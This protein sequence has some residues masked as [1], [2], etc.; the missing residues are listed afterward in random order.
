MKAEAEKS[1]RFDVNQELNL[2]S[3]QTFM[4]VYFEG[5]EESI[6]RTNELLEDILEFNEEIGKKI[7]DEISLKSIVEYYERDKD[8]LTPENYDRDDMNEK[9]KLHNRTQYELTRTILVN[10]KKWMDFIMD[11][12]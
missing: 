12:Y 7:G 4:D 6:D 9:D 11:K 8:Y 3:L 2:D 5:K 1:G 10:H